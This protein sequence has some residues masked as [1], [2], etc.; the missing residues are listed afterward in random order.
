MR[1]SRIVGGMEEVRLSRR[2]LLVSAGSGV[3]GIAVVNTLA[4]CSD[5]DDPAGSTASST[6]GA[7]PSGAPA[8]GEWQRVD[9]A[10]VSAYVLVR[11]GEA[12]VVDLGTEGSAQSIETVL[13][14]AGSGWGSVKH[15]ILTHQ[16]SDHAGGLS[17]VAPLVDAALYAGA[18][19]VSAI[20]S[21]K[22]LQPLKDGDE[23]FGL[24]IVGTP[25][26][27]AGHVSVF[28][29]S[30]GVLVAGDALRATAGLEGPDARYTADMAQAA[31]SVRK[32][33]G[34]EVKTILPG[35]GAPVTTGAADALTK[36]AASLK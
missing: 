22:P 12:A 26:H 7:S 34:L 17:E 27:T 4:A 13:K 15:V 14:A 25:G 29:P 24:R 19:D 23:I 36:L 10:F 8:T 5:T 28:D 11:G 33:A 1:T 21:T 32:L 16:H 2:R 3:L 31:A 20:S 6:P 9:L 30:T 18:D 35:H